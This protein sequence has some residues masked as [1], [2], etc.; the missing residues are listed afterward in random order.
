LPNIILSYGDTSVILKDIDN[1]ESLAAEYLGDPDKAIEIATY[2]GIASLSDL[3]PGDTIRIP[4]TEQT[5]QMSNNLIFARREERDN[6]G[7][8]IRLDNNKNIMASNTGDYSLINGVNN[9]TQAILLRLRESVAKRI[10]IGAYGIRVNIGDPDAGVAFIVES[11]R[12]TVSSDPRVSS[13]DN[14]R[15]RARGDILD[16]EIFYHDINNTSGIISG[17]V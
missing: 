13:V 4:I 12:L 9:L 17:R 7:R 3:N 15:Y 11:I 10:R 2:N 1:L 14:I 8:D 6:Y 16:V 5:V